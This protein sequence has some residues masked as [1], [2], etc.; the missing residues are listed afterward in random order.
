[1]DDRTRELAALADTAKRAKPA[2]PQRVYDFEQL[3]GHLA[4]T[5]ETAAADMLSEA[6][7]LAE[8]ARLLVA[9]IR[10]SVNEQSK[11]LSDINARLKATGEQMLEAARKFNG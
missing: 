6:Q 5:M 9:D 1:M 2:A 4:D 8:H 11:L 7:K 3:G 10:A